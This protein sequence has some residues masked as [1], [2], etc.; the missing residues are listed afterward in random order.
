M[1][2]SDSQGLLFTRAIYTWSKAKCCVWISEFARITKRWLQAETNFKLQFPSAHVIIRE[3]SHW[4]KDLTRGW[5]FDKFL[6]KLEF[7]RP[8]GAIGIHKYSPTSMKDVANY[9]LHVRSR[10]TRLIFSNSQVK[11]DMEMNL[12]AINFSLSDSQ[13]A[14]EAHGCKPWLTNLSIVPHTLGILTANITY[15]EYNI[16]F[17]YSNVSRVKVHEE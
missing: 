14:L 11:R 6:P 13:K 8:I 12:T 10:E 2:R 9:S 7:E 3:F 1:K 5:Y 17:E 4:C 15:L 16:T